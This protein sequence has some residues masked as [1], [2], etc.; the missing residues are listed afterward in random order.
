[1]VAMGD[2]FMEC[3]LSSEWPD[4]LRVGV[5]RV[6]AADGRTEAD[7]FA[8][9]LDVHHVVA[10]GLDGARPGRLVMS[11]WSINVHD[12]VNAAIIPRSFHQGRGLHR[13]AF[14]ELVNGR[15]IS[16]EIFAERVAAQAG[17]GPGR[18]IILKTIQKIG[19]EL[20]LLSG[21][22]GAL[23][24]QELLRARSAVAGRRVGRVPDVR[25]SRAAGKVGDGLAGPER[26]LRPRVGADRDDEAVLAKRGH[27]L[28]LA[29]A[30]RR[31]DLA[32]AGG[33]AGCGS[34]GGA[35]A[36]ALG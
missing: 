9:G 15:L 5:I 8:R 26:G 12:V 11:R 25:R 32:G 10:A 28:P 35:E 24:L 36:W 17:F 22:P 29:P 16:A 18:L 14:L 30:C 33:R 13:S 2:K 4:R 6:L 23:A 7:W 27:R 34:V 1:M 20:V 19:S 3:S 31:C 21:D